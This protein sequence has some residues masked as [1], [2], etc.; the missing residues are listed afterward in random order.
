MPTDDTICAIATPPGTGGIGVFRVS[1][2]G[3]FTICDKLLRHSR[4]CKSYHGHTL[5]RAAVMDG[6]DA[7]DDV[8]VAVFHAPGSYTGEDVVEISCHGGPVPMRRVL[9]RLLASGA[10]MAEPGEFTLRAFLNGKMD[11]AQAEAVCDI[12]NARTAEAHELA[13]ALGGG[14]L[15]QEVG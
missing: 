14:R 11:L 15:S 2:P 6:K 7:V 12:I 8:L 1:G 13:Q 10:R 5:H 4:P 3:A 9:E